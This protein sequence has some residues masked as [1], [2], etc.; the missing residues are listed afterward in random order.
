MAAGTAR[1]A[2]QQQIGDVHRREHQQQAGRGEENDENGTEIADRRRE[3]R[4]DGK[5]SPDF[6]VR[7]LAAE[8]LE[9]GV[10]A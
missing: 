10:D 1:G 7:V 3:Q 8:R 6:L 5:R 2:G 9:R 4:A